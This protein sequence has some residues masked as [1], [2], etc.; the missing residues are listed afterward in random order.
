[1]VAQAGLELMTFLLPQPLER[2][3]YRSTPPH[4][5]APIAQITPH[6]TP[7]HLRSYFLL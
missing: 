6:P 3:A 2:W 5:V 7:F 1:M 4:T